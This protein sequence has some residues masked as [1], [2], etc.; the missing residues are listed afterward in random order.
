MQVP[1]D[2]DPEARRDGP[3]AVIDS[4]FERVSARCDAHGMKKTRT[5]T[6]RGRGIQVEERPAVEKAHNLTM[7]SVCQ[8]SGGA[9]LA[10][11][12][13]GQGATQAQRTVSAPAHTQAVLPWSLPAVQA[14]GLSSA[15]RLKGDLEVFNG[16]GNATQHDD[17]SDHPLQISRSS[18][19]S[20]QERLT[21]ELHALR[22]QLEVSRKR[23]K[24]YNHAL[25]KLHVELHRA[26]RFLAKLQANDRQETDA[27]LCAIEEST[28]SDSRPHK[29]P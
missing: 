4:I 20:S 14:I 23:Q 13:V 15:D 21:M 17:S 3:Q 1:E 9:G 10:S 26:Y 12:T 22:S 19:N 11:S 7:D 24:T 27:M 28:A 5:S 2:Q 25:G 16:C 8:V 18:R 29:L 6:T